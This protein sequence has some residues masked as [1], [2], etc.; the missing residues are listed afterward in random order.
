[1]HRARIHYSQG[2]SRFAW[3]LHPPFTLPMAV[4]TSSFVAFC[5]WAAGAPNPNGGAYSLAKGGY[6]GT[7]LAHMKPTSGGQVRP[8]AVVLWSPPVPGTPAAIVVRTGPAPLLVSHGSEAGP[9]LIRFSK[10][11][12]RQSANG[13]N[14]TTWLT[15][16]FAHKTTVKS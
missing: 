7:M 8:G 2:S 11:N 13:H 10:E 15:V 5:Y 3:L 1:A 14:Q 4:D 12:R 6:T 9:E 16:F